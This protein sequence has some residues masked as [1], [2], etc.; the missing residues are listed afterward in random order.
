MS[1]VHV[2]VGIVGAG[3]RIDASWILIA[4]GCGSRG[5]VPR[6]LCLPLWLRL[7]VPLGLRLL[8]L[9]LRVPLWLRL[10]VPLWLRGTPLRLRI[11]QARIITDGEVGAV[12][13]IHASRILGSRLVLWLG[14][15]Q[16]HEG[17][18]KLLKRFKKN[19]EFLNVIRYICS[20][21][22]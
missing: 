11:V 12:L 17:S 22:V 4:T 13:R 6:G 7:G 1:G 2:A 10:G 20:L 21:C 9:W 3:L 19:M 5:C 16:G 18:E 15:R 14:H 8:P